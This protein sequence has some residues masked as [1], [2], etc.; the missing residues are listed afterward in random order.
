MS[1]NISTKRK[2]LS[3]KYKIFDTDN[4]F[5]NKFVKKELKTSK[6]INNNNSNF[7]SKNKKIKLKKFIIETLYKTGKI[8]SKNKYA[9]DNFLTDDMFYIKLTS[10][11]NAFL[12]NRKL[13]E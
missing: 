6:N 4:I 2:K 13:K 10:F 3:Q 1:N 9:I 7:N 12:K 8:T 5:N 11:L